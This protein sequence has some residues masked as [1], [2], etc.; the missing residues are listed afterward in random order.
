MEEAE[1]NHEPD[2]GLDPGL[3]KKKER[4]KKK[5]L[6]SFA[7]KAIIKTTG[8]STK[9]CRL[10][11]YLIAMLISCGYLFFKKYTRQ[12]LEVK[13]EV[14]LSAANSQMIWKRE[15]VCVCVHTE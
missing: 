9:V 6:F 14:I 5:K 11:S 10:D 12:C 2:L 8:E 4:R 15:G 3:G 7:I 1:K 13:E